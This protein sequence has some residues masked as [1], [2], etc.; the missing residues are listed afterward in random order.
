LSGLQSGR[1]CMSEVIVF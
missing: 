1:F